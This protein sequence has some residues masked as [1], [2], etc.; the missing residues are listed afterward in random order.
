MESLIH[1]SKKLV[2]SLNC[3][4]WLLRNVDCDLGLIGFSMVIIQ[5][6]KFNGNWPM[7]VLD[8]LLV[9]LTL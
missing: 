1:S 2:R 9:D 5:P 6:L 7:L 3:D 4:F 8:R